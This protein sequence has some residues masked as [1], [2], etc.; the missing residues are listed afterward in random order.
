MFQQNNGGAGT[1]P[2][3]YACRSRCGFT[4]VELPAVSKQKLAAFTLVELLVV[5][6]I[7]AVL[8]AILMPAL[9]N[10]RA[11]SD[12]TVCL[13]NLH[14]ISIATQ[15]YVQENKNYPPAWVDSTTRWMDLIKPY[16]AKSS[17]VYQCPGDPLKIAVPWDSTIILSYGIN[18]FNF[19]NS[20][21][22]CFWYGVNP[23]A[24]RRPSEIIIF[25]DCTP[26]DYW[27]GSGSRL[28]YPVAYVDY[29][30]CNKSFCAAFC[31]GHA[32]PKTAT[33]QLDWD[34]SQ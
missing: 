29:R 14:Q 10:A 34:V 27:C 3:G 25:A 12:R 2:G 28:T 4:L 13:S 15:M 5:I 23:S 18:T 32:E 9:A 7:I 16:I 22:T 26:G 11:Q 19:A 30:H 20:P 31:D 33:T 6:G 1:V 24:V 8:V 21:K 17:N